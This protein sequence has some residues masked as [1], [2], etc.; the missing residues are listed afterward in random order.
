MQIENN[1]PQAD[2]EVQC[3]MKPKKP[4]VHK[5]IQ[6][7]VV[8]YGIHVPVPS[9]RLFVADDGSVYVIVNLSKGGVAHIS[10]PTWIKAAKEEAAAENFSG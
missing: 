3:V 10:L 9:R 4:I 5:A 2:Q 6:T 7:K 8:M 1:Q